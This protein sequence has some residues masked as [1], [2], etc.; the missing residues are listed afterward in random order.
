M[1]EIWLSLLTV[2]LFVVYSQA[3]KKRPPSED[4]N[5]HVE[6]L[7][8]LI[9]EFEK[10][11]KEL[12]QSV[13]RIKRA[14]DFELEGMKAELSA[15]R[16]QIAHLTKQYGQLQ[17]LIGETV[18]NR[19]QGDGRNEPASQNFL[20]LKD[21][22]REIPAMYAQGHTSQ[23]IARKLGIGNGEVEMV[24]QM[25]KRQQKDSTAR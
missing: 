15:A 18:H 10:E 16:E 1:I 11:N 6:Q 20:F 4:T 2:A 17:T 9:D 25:I 3:N 7:T 24:I 14:T 5:T 19:L 22:Y 13:A 21:E 12:V 8:A 23:D